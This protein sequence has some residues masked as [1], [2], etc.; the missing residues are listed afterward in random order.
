MALKKRRKSTKGVK[1]G[2]RRLITDDLIKEIL[3]DAATLTQVQIAAKHR[4]STMTIWRILK[5]HPRDPEITERKKL[6]PLK[7]VEILAGDSTSVLELTIHSM[8]TLLEAEIKAKKANPEAKSTITVREL[9][10]FFEIVAPYV[11]KKADSIPAKKGEKTPL[12]M[13]HN[14]FAKKPVS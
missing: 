1:Q 9:K 3:V 12:G 7:R 6:D 10:D 14:M 8:K 13:V 5:N 4:L 11:L 2:N